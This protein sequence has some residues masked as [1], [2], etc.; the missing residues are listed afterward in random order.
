MKMKNQISTKNRIKKTAA[1]FFLAVE[2]L[3]DIKE[4]DRRM[5]IC[6]GCDKFRNDDQTCGVCG[7]F[8]DVKTKLKTNHDGLFGKVIETHCPL[9]R[10]GDKEIANKYRRLKGEPELD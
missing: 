6:L 5:N 3:P 4:A 10:W 9:G 7:C 2:E 1:K 8:M